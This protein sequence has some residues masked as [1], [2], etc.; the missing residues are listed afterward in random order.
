MGFSAHRRQIYSCFHAPRRRKRSPASIL[1]RLASTFCLKYP[2]A[3]SLAR[4]QKGRLL[5]QPQGTSP[6]HR[7]RVFLSTGVPSSFSRY[8]C[9]AVVCT[10]LVIQNAGTQLVGAPVVAGAV[11][12]HVFME[13]STIMKQEAVLALQHPL[14]IKGPSVWKPWNIPRLDVNFGLEGGGHGSRKS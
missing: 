12:L 6:P 10:F 1:C 9:F 5:N 7:V 8:P 4:P 3:C 11:A 13:V 2:P 14:T